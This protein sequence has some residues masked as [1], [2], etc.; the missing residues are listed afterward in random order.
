MLMGHSQTHNN[1]QVLGI[2]TEYTTSSCIL[3]PTKAG[4]LLWNITYFIT[5]VPHFI[6]FQ[7]WCNS[8]KK[9]VDGRNM[10]QTILYHYTHS[11]RF[12]TENKQQLSSGRD[13]I[14]VGSFLICGEPFNVKTLLTNQNW[15]FLGKT[16]KSVQNKFFR[17]NYTCQT[18][19]YLERCVS[20]DT[21]K[22]APE[23]QWPVRNDVRRKAYSCRQFPL[24]YKWNVTQ[25]KTR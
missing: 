12:V 9:A 19:N 7:I 24:V 14:R 15:H 17:S 1:V 23:I 2:R 13:M 3:H 8:L 22:Q 21:S 20:C 11:V 4:T 16:W 25:K 18:F 5:T 6:E 10:Q